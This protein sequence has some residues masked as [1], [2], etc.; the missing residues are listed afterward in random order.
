MPV[1]KVNLEYNYISCRIFIYQIHYNFNECIRKGS[2]KS[3]STE[4]FFT[5]PKNI[6]N[7]N[8]ELLH[9][10]HGNISGTSC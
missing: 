10:V 5:S 3:E 8:P 1:F 7:L 6:P 4:G 9:P 2:L